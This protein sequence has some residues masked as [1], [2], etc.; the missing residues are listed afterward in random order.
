MKGLK[1][2][3]SLFGVRE[4][5]LHCFA[6]FCVQINSLGLR[7]GPEG[8]HGMAFFW[9]EITP[10]VHLAQLRATA[11][12]P[13]SLAGIDNHQQLLPGK[14]EL[15]SSSEHYAGTLCQWQ[16][17]VGNSSFLLLLVRQS[18]STA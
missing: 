11:A 16:R 7:E 9:H 8:V 18:L 14:F 6:S 15:S 10:P 2:F 4:I 3:C 5:H 12:S 1:A 13:T 17:G